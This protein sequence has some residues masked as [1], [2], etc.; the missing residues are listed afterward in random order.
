MCPYQSVSSV[1]LHYVEGICLEPL[2]SSLH[3]SRRLPKFSPD[4]ALVSSS[5]K[6]KN[7]DVNMTNLRVFMK[8]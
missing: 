6:R 5:E 7:G 1:A 8:I 3:K 4:Y 2:R